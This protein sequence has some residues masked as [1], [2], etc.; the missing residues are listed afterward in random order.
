MA[1]TRVG[2]PAFMSPEQA[3]GHVDRL[4][5]PSDIY[6][7]GAT[8]YNILTG[9]PPF[10]GSDLSKTLA[11]VVDWR[12]PPAPAGQSLGAPAARG[13]RPEGHGTSARGPLRLTQG[14]ARRHRA[15]DGR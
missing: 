11:R 2:T 8:L 13:H 1:G 3:A 15:L 9:K 4:G 6:S 10:F 7:L 5:P 12:F 14:P